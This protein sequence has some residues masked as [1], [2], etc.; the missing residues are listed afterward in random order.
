MEREYLDVL[1]SKGNKTG[2]KLHRE[3]I[4][5]KGYWHQSVHIWLINNKNEVLLQKRS[6]NKSSNPGMLDLSCTG[7]LSSGE[8]ILEGALR[9]LKEELNISADKNELKYIATV[10][11]KR[12]ER[13]K[14][15]NNKEHCTVYIL[16][17]NIDLNDIEYNTRE[18]S[19]V[20]YVSYNDLM[21]L[22]KDKNSQLIKYTDEYKI[23]IP[24][25]KKA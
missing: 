24:M 9:E 18:V 3:E 21:K 1:D 13:K 23:V 8:D 7:H 17:S 25:L 14:N 22:I 19:E 12:I 10:K 11:R 4:H 16:K 5:K 20:L 2:I 6:L 15:Y